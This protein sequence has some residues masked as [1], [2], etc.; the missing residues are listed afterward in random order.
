MARIINLPKAL[1]SRFYTRGRYSPT[2]EQGTHHFHRLL[3]A[4]LNGAKAAPKREG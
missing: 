2:H 4:F 1:T 3:A